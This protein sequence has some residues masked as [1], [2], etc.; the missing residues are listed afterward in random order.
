MRRT[1][2]F[3]AAGVLLGGI[4][5][6]AVIFLLP[7]F[8]NRDAW[9]SVGRFGPDGAFHLLPM[10]EPGTEALPALDP[11]MAHAVCRFSLTGRPVHL[12]ARLPDVFWSLAVFD[13]RGRNV[14]SLNDRS[15]ERAGLDLV[16]ATPAQMQAL[17]DS[18]PDALETAIIVEVPAAD[19]FALLRA[20]VPDASLLG[21]VRAAL[22]AADCNA[23]L[24]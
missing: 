3:L 8:A 9:S 20:F 15:A 6:I 18:L 13:R 16:I 4:I 1:L 17:R 21:P 23:P 22:A 10:A 11:F 14:Y 7:G 5:H 24:T 2:L 12:K 19:N